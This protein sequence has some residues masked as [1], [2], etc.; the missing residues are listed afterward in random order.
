MW[1]GTELGVSARGRECI[2][3]VCMLQCSYMT[4]GGSVFVLTL[5]TK[6]LKTTCVLMCVCASI[7]YSRARVCCTMLQPY[8][9]AHTAGSHTQIH[10]IVAYCII[11]L[12]F[13]V[14][15]RVS[16]MRILRHFLQTRTRDHWMPQVTLSDAATNPAE[17]NRSSEEGLQGRGLK[18]QS[19]HIDHST[20]D[21]AHV[22]TILPEPCSVFSC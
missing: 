8:P 20:H 15:R 18:G 21:R 2:C 10:K 11:V 9:D 1:R 19:K 13:T 7:L 3:T 5:K 16:K 6:C 14:P 17:A 4:V 12:F 22:A